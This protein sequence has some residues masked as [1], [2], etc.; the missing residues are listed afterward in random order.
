MLSGQVVRDTV[1]VIGKDIHTDWAIYT[2][3]SDFPVKPGADA[4]VVMKSVEMRTARLRR[5][6]P[7]R[8]LSR[9]ER[10]LDIEEKG[11]GICRY[12]FRLDANHLGKQRLL[13]VKTRPFIP[14]AINAYSHE[15]FLDPD[16]FH[17]WGDGLWASFVC[18]L[19][20]VRRSTLAKHVR[21]VNKGPLGHGSPDILNIPFTFNVVDPEFRAAPWVV[22]GHKIAHVHDKSPRAEPYV[23]FTHGGVHPSTVAFLSVDVTD[24]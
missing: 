15:T 3:H 9:P 18:D 22:P 1:F 5:L 4:E 6:P 7:P 21:N 20:K 16:D 8:D 10:Y 19:T 23:P 11:S 13:F 2:H 12:S 24:G 14:L 17:V